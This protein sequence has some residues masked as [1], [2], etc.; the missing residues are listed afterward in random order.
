MAQLLESNSGFEAHFL[1]AFFLSGSRA[2]LRTEPCVWAQAA[3]VPSSAERG[4][5]RCCR[6]VVEQAL[7]DT[8]SSCPAAGGREHRP[9]LKS[10][11]F[12]LPC[13]ADPVTAC[14]WGLQFIQ[15]ALLSFLMQFLPFALFHPFARHHLSAQDVES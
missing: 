14:V 13:Q 3:A 2:V 6:A 11:L 5:P 9:A 8:V 7:G 10:E 1:S 4:C 15:I 12:T